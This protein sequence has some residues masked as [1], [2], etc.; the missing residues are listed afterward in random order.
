MWN[1]EDW[2]NYFHFIFPWL[3]ILSYLTNTFAF[4]SLRKSLQEDSFNFIS[5]LWFL[6][7]F[8]SFLF[9]KHKFYVKLMDEALSREMK[10]VTKNLSNWWITFAKMPVAVCML[11]FFCYN[12]CQKLFGSSQKK[13]YF[14]FFVFSLRMLIG[15]WFNHE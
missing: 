1:E 11:L 4:S 2:M 6:K 10:R 13:F 14:W 15:C 5:N 7:L 12:F 8:H 9:W 3:K